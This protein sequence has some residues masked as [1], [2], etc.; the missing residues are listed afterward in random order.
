MTNSAFIHR[1]W[2]F[3]EGN[4]ESCDE[5]YDVAF[6]LAPNIPLTNASVNAIASLTETL[7]SNIHYRSII[8]SNS[9]DNTKTP[10]IF[11]NNFG[12]AQYNQPLKLTSWDKGQVLPRVKKLFFSPISLSWRIYAQSCA[13]ACIALGVKTLVIED[14]ADF[15][16]VVRK[17][18]KKGI[19]IILHQHAFTQRNYLSYQWKRIQKQLDLVVFVSTNTL[20]RT[21]KQHGKLIAPARVIYNGV[22]LDLFDP[23]KFTIPAARLRKQLDINLEERVVIF[24]GRFVR[25]K[26]L[27]DALKAYL[28]MNNH[29]LHFLVIASKENGGDKLFENEVLL[30]RSQIDTLRLPLHYYENVSPEEV[31][32]F[33][34][35]SDLVLLPSIGH[36]GL[37]KVITES[38]AMGVP[39]IASDRGG[40]WELLQV[41]RNAWK[42]DDP[43]NP[44]TI[45]KALNEA[46][47]MDTHSLGSMKNEIIVADRPN[48]DQWKM[49]VEFNRVLDLVMGNSL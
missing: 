48:M 24:V 2:S 10:I 21:E 35:V 27:L 19:K 12:R 22:D 33:Y 15:G 47:S 17:V 23:Q 3:M 7:A 45:L 37:P 43:V 32:V 28:I 5:S 46:L 25:S 14:V 44:I 42:I 29:N 9:P 18:R 30:L 49:I 8:F 26:G 4:L 38:L 36:E 13:E 31:P 34:S 11:S 39:V 40:I 1:D 20:T 16:W 6:L 41:G